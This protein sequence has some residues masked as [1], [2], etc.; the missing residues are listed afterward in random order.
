V[1][2]GASMSVAL[3]GLLI[4]NFDLKA[5]AEPGEQGRIQFGFGIGTND[6]Q[7]TMLRW[8]VAGACLVPLLWFGRRR[9]L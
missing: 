4:A 2:V 9:A 3:G 5:P 8:A 7:S 6:M 1:I